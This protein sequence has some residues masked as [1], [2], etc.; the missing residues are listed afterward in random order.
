[1]PPS[2]L[3]RPSQ[4][5]AES[6]DCS[7]K[8]SRD[9]NFA[10]AE[11]FDER[12]LAE[13]GTKLLQEISRE[14][15]RLPAANREQL[16]E[17][18]A[19]L[20][21]PYDEIQKAFIKD[22]IRATA[23]DLAKK[24][25]ELS[26]LMNS[27]KN[28]DRS[29]PVE[30]ATPFIDIN[31]KGMAPELLSAFKANPTLGTSIQARREQLTKELLA[32]NLEAWQRPI[33]EDLVGA[34]QAKN[35]RVKFFRDETESYCLKRLNGEDAIAFKATLALFDQK[36]RHLPA[37]QQQCIYKELTNFASA[38]KLPV[39]QPERLAVL[40]KFM[41]EA[42][43]S[44]SNDGKTVRK[45]LFKAGT[46]E[47]LSC[48]AGIPVSDEKCKQTHGKGLKQIFEENLSGE[49]LSA[50]Q[51]SLI[52]LVTS[53]NASVEHVKELQ[54]AF[55]SQPDKIKN[56]LRSQGW[57]VV[58]TRKISTAMPE[59]REVKPRGWPPGSTWDNASALCDA[60][61]K[62]IVIAE[63]SLQG[64]DGPAAKELKVGHTLGRCCHEIG[65]AVDHALK[66]ASETAEFKQAYEKDLKDQEKLPDAERKWMKE[67]FAYFLQPGEAGRQEAWADLYAASI[68]KNSYPVN[69]DLSKY[70][71]GAF[72][73]VQTQ[74]SKIPD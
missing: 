9:I 6:M 4:M 30:K 15:E 26:K 59:L 53:V 25:D 55:D 28:M 2:G 50:A 23:P 66:G 39:E 22:E 11:K 14:Y 43:I 16:K 5:K 48:R 33:L 71:P 60:S 69:K 38:G 45:D 47:V 49:D 56:L 42:S 40:S 29:G 73:I 24:Y 17:L 41:R 36:I 57:Q 58:A 65:H 3:E 70:F 46:S 7:E 74:I 44:S 54:A 34:D 72:K 67:A 32:P 8:L 62:R 51:K 31:L 18:R 61:T 37:E 64:L 52:D 1:M 68:G 12:L 63:N 21:L 35:L 27:S 20:A 19:Q 10:R 13:K